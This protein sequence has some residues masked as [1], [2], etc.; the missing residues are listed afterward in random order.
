[1]DCLFV[2]RGEAM[3]EEVLLDVRCI[4]EV[5]AILLEVVDLFQLPV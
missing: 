3:S 1:M 5:V 2:L 4:V